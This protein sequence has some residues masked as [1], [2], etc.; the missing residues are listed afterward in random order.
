MVVACCACTHCCN[1]CTHIGEGQGMRLTL[2]SHVVNMAGFSTPHRAST[3]SGYSNKIRS[4]LAHINVAVC[5]I[6]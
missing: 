4:H 2:I 1:V 5:P 3:N 6:Q